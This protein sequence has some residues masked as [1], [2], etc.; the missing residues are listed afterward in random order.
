VNAPT[1]SGFRSRSHRQMRMLAPSVAMQKNTG[2]LVGAFG[3]CWARPTP[4]A[5]LII[6]RGAADRYGCRYL[7]IHELMGAEWVVLVASV[8][9]CLVIAGLGA[10]GWCGASAAQ[11]AV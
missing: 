5:Q 2:Q 7:G 3:P 9:Q 10:A 8:Q 1:P 4:D 11:A 6:T